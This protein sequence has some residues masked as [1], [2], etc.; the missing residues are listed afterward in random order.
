MKQTLQFLFIVCIYST[1]EQ[2][3]EFSLKLGTVG[4]GL[5]REMYFLGFSKEQNP[6]LGEEKGMG[7][8]EENYEEWAQVLWML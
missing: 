4:S 6:V 7:R 5:R 2:L 3:T 8:E 1:K